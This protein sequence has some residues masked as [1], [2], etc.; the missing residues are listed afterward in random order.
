MPFRAIMIVTSGRLS[1]ERAAHAIRQARSGKPEMRKDF[2]LKSETAKALYSVVRELPIIDFHNH[3]SVKDMA[4]DRKYADISEL[5]LE[6]DPYK[7][8]LMRICG[9]EEHYITGDAAPV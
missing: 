3:L 2:L 8:R 1:Q 9:I 4:T 5:W 6:S 7:H